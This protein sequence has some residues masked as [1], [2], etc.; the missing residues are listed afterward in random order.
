MFWGGLV[1][2]GLV[3]AVVVW[4]VLVE[5]MEIQNV[6]VTNQAATMNKDNSQL[7]S[8]QI[9][10]ND[11]A[12][13]NQV[14]NKITKTQLNPTAKSTTINEG[15]NWPE[16][17]QISNQEIPNHEK[18]LQIRSPPFRMQRIVGRTSL[19]NLDKTQ[20]WTEKN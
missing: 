1:F 8:T 16:N 2:V 18:W 20:W 14:K 4:V 12:L 6:P 3:L 13:H 19:S 10:P 9:K 11:L 15:P 5:A 7:N 17:W